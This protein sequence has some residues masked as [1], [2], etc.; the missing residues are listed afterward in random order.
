[1]GLMNGLG[2]VIYKDA[3]PTAL[4]KTEQII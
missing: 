3:A 4:P 2:T 1:M